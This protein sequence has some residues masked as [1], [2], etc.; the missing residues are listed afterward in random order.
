MTTLAEILAGH[1]FHTAASVD[2][3]YYL[4]GRDELRP[5]LPVLLFQPGDRTPCGR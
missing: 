2:T 1:G 5:G 4:R 3:P